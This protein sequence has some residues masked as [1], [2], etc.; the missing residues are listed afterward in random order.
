M[1]KSMKQVVFTIF[2]EN[3]KSYE[4]TTAVPEEV[5][6]ADH[7]YFLS[8]AQSV[9]GTLFVDISKVPIAPNPPSDLAL[10]EQE[11]EYLRSIEMLESGL[12]VF[13]YFEVSPQ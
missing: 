11:N 4:Y 5:D 3:G 12:I 8:I 7:D 13:S 1:K 6:T 9:E 10:V 2:L